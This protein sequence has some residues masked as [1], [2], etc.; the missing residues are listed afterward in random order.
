MRLKDKIAIITGSCTTGIGFNI[1]KGF[2]KEGAHVVICGLTDEEVNDGRERM[3]KEFPES[4][5]LAYKL[6]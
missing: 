4:D 5:F 6:P 2:I 3:A 1:A